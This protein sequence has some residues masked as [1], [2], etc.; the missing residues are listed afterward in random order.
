ML[1][2][3]PID[4]LGLV[5]RKPFG[6]AVVDH[7]AFGKPDKATGELAGER[8][9]DTLRELE[10]FQQPRKRKRRRKRRAFPTS[11]EEA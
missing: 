7:L 5:H 11:V 8:G 3:A 1:F 10:E 6:R 2:V 9:I 4:E